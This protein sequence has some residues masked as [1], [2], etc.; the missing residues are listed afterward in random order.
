MSTLEFVLP[1]GS[2]DP[3][4]NACGRLTEDPYGGPCKA[5]WDT[6]GRDDDD[7]PRC[8]LVEGR[9]VCYCT[10]RAGRQRRDDEDDRCPYCD[11][12]TCAGDCDEAFADEDDEG[13]CDDPYCCAPPE[14][15]VTTIDTGGLT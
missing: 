1:E 6:V 4:P 10:S 8:T 15:D 3:C 7:Y 5:C 12:K 9:T 11:S 14:R 2:P 13:V